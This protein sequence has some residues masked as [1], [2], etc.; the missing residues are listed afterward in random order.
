MGKKKVNE[1]KEVDSDS[2]DDAEEVIEEVKEAPKIN[3]KTGKPYLSDEEKLKIRR[4]NMQKA[5]EAKQQKNNITKSLKEKKKELTKV[6]LEQKK[7]ELEELEQRLEEKKQEEAR[8]LSSRRTKPKAQPI[9]PIKPKKVV[10]V[11]D[12]SDDEDDPEEEKIIVKRKKNKSLPVVNEE[13]YTQ[14]IKQSAVEQLQKRL[15]NE[16]IRMS[17]LSIAPNYRF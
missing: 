9:K 4:E 17:L 7:K 16:R 14:L 11:E 1:V 10:E 2:A 8:L 5:I 15:E 13:D 12:D 6:E 3:K